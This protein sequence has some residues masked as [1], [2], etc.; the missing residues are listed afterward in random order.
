MALLLLLI[1]NFGL[2]VT[3]PGAPL[4]TLQ[5]IPG[6]Y[7]H[8]TKRNITSLGLSESSANLLPEGS[9]LLCSRATIGE[10]KIAK[11][12][13]STNQ[14]FKSLVCN[15]KVNNEFMYYKVLTLKDKLLRFSVGSTFLEF[16][17]KDISRLE[18]DLPKP[19][20]QKAIADCLSSIDELITA[21]TQKTDALKAHKKGLMQKLFPAEGETVPKLRF[22]EFRD[23]G[24][25]RKTILDNYADFYKGKFLPKSTICD[26]A[27]F[28]CIHYGELFTHYPEK[29]KVIKS[30]TNQPIA[31]S[32]LSKNNDV[33]MP[34]SDVTPDGLAKA[35][36][37]FEDD[38]ILGGDILVIRSKKNN[39]ING[40]FLSYFIRFNKKEIMK[41]V[42]GT[43]VY[44]LYASDLKSF[45][46]YFTFF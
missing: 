46:G 38:V 16:H 41:R 6:K 37:I 11:T 4:Q 28:K 34:T 45:P 9:L 29:I 5:K 14:G 36:C 23:A 10:V 30:R 39:F 33:L 32:F 8:R 1:L 43:T 26:S 7:I 19:E 25:W 31:T 18:I 24:E 21:Q 13:I 42:T 35:S 22:P 15:D 27:K 40:V 17:K 44:H 3:Y 2:K 12:K 20:E